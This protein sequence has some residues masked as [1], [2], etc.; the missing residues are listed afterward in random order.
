MSLSATPDYR[1]ERVCRVRCDAG[2][3]LKQAEGR[4]G[5]EIRADTMLLVKVA[6]VDIRPQLTFR[7]RIMRGRLLKPP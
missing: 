2:V 6:I 7:R 4:T 1:T 3:P 5:G